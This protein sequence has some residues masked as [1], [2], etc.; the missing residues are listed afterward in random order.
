MSWSSEK[1]G[2][3][4]SS[5]SKV[6]AEAALRT[7]QAGVIVEQEDMATEARWGIKR[8]SEWRISRMQSWKSSSFYVHTRDF[9]FKNQKFTFK[10]SRHSW[11]LV[12]EA[13]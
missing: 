2:T 13:T 11:R 7:G 1:P 12:S 8:T 9:A 5:L 10:K 3:D 6:A 4:M